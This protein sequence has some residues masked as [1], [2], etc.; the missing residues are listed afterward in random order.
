HDGH[1]SEIDPAAGTVRRVLAIAPDFA[2]CETVATGQGIANLL[3]AVAIAPAGDP[4]VA[5]QLWVGGTLHNVLRK[6][7]FERSRALKDKP[8]VALFPD[9]DFQSNSAG[10]GQA[11]HRNLYKAGVHDIARS[12]VWKID[13]ASGE[14]RG[15]LDVGGGGSIVGIAF[16]PQGG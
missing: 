14:S 2:T 15:K 16:A 12:I 8:G 9:L 13:L 3:S 11:A 4:S 6:G 10:E 7:L 1:V 5:G